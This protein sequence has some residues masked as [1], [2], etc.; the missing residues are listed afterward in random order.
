MFCFFCFF[1]AYDDYYLRKKIN[2]LRK[3]TTTT[4]TSWN[5]VKEWVL[6]TLTPLFRTHQTNHFAQIFDKFGHLHLT[7]R[8][9][10]LPIAFVSLSDQA[11]NYYFLCVLLTG[12]RNI[13][14]L[15]RRIIDW[16]TQYIPAFT[17]YQI[18]Y[19][20]CFLRE[21]WVKKFT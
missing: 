7:I 17:Q 11:V 15:S 6:W 5:K 18:K 8:T 16:S 4:K 9:F 20:F 1:I 19:V 13:S 3:T 21:L 2:K 10:Q 12:Y 14:A